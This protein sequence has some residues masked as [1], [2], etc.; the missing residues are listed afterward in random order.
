M[1]EEETHVKFF[2]EEIG[3]AIG[4]AQI[5]GGISP[6]FN[7]ETDGAALERGLN[8]SDALAVGVVEAFGDAQDG[9]QAAGHALVE[10]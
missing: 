5:L 8:T 10:V 4:V 2:F 7:L 9:G 3:A 1:A 6:G